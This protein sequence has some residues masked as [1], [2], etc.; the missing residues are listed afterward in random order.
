MSHRL[1]LI[2]TSGRIVALLECVGHAADTCDVQSWAENA[3]FVDE[4][5]VHHTVPVEIEWSPNGEPSMAFT[6]G[7]PAPSTQG[8]K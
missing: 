8:E 7:V 5:F 3:D 6:H 4:V 2:G 1:R